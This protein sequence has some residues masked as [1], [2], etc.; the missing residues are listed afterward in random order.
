MATLA[1]VLAL[2][3]ACCYAVA[4][5]LQQQAAATTGG[6]SALSPRLLVRLARQPRWLGGI[7]ATL[8]GAGFT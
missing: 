3:S 6:D 2:V 8:L 4:A 5:V 7:G 1:L